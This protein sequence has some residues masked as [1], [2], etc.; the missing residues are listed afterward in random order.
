MRIGIDLG[1][2]K[3]EAAAFA[4]DGCELVR[5]RIPTP[6]DDYDATLSAI[7]DLIRTIERR[8]GAAGTVGIGIPGAISRAKSV[9]KNA[10]STWLNGRPL[11]DDLP[12]LL[13][14]PV[15]FEN[16]A[17]CFALSEAVDGAAAGADVV[18]G[19]IVGTGTGGDIVVNGRVLHGANE[20]AGEWGTIRC[21]FRRRASG[22]GPIATAGGQAVSRRF[23]RGRVWRAT[24][25]LQAAARSRGRR[26]RSCR[27]RPGALVHE[28]ELTRSSPHPV[29]VTGRCRTILAGQA[30][31]FDSGHHTRAVPQPSALQ[32]FWLEAPPRRSTYTGSTRSRRGPA[33]GSRTPS[34]TGA[35]RF[36]SP[37]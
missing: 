2:T 29:F 33:D 32:E 22:H 34:S 4:D 37:S 9:V 12:R 30:R 28:Y 36:A 6:R 5:Q 8:T 25:R 7:V 31:S 3:I 24:T 20:I 21:P 26:C 27:R 18:F 11:G 14:R 16:D 23:Y 1:G 35:D 15:R 13:E 19:A 17:N 10:N